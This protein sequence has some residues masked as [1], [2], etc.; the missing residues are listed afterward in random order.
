VTRR[1]FPTRILLAA[2]AGA[3]L[4]G[5][6]AQQLDPNLVAATDVGRYGG[7][8]VALEKKLPQDPSDRSYILE[9]LRL[10]ILTLADGQPG[11]AEEVANQTFRLLRTQGLNAD[12]T[13]AS[14]VLNE[15]VKIWKGEPFEQALGFTYVAIQKAEVGQWDNA[16]AAAGA[17]LFLLKSFGDNERGQ[18]MS[19]IE[20]ARR[21]AEEDA[22]K[23]EGAGDKYINKGYTPIKTNFVLGYLLDGLANKALGRTD[24]AN[25]NFHEAAVINASLEPL[26]KELATGTYNTVFIVDF[27]RGPEKI[28]TGPDGAFSRFVPRTP[29]DSSPLTVSVTAGPESSGGGINVFAAKSLPQVQDIN[30][31][32]ASLM[33]N[34]LE[35]VRQAKSAVGTGLLYGGLA[36][37]AYGANGGGGRHHN[38]T[39]ALAGLGAAAA[40]L[41]LKSTAHADTRHAEFLPQRVYVVPLNI[42]SRAS[43]VTLDVGGGRLVLPAIDPP[44]DPR[45]LQL[46]YV[47]MN[48]APGQPW[49]ASGQVVYSNDYSQ[50]RVDGDTL[51]YIM[52]GRDCSTPSPRVLERYQSAGNLRNMTTVDLENLYREEGIAL[53][54]EDQ[55]GRSRKHILEGG[56]SLVAPLPGTAGY[57]RLFDQIHEPYKPKSKALEE[58]LSQLRGEQR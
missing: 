2:L 3:A 52:G 21:A 13:A 41:L 54:L 53:T 32:A 12:R 29:S 19:N 36:A 1:V 22:R 46:R 27:G 20:V 55:Q 40:G 44:T 31:M 17:S 42:A 33:W 23:G 51:P 7:A 38:E 37:A 8:R 28:A 18:E 47:R 26:A 11:A 57:A 58:L 25:D 49:A 6:Q 5:C 39:V 34:N 4:A 50:W 10:L 43:T 16:R 24:E 15:D 48:P 30:R 56:D 9:R 14:I 35:D 45:G